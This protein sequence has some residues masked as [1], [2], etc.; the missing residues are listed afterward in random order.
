M[1]IINLLLLLIISNSLLAVEL[2]VNKDCHP[3]LTS[4]CPLYEAMP[5]EKK[6]TFIISFLILKNYYEHILNGLIIE[7]PDE[8]KIYKSDG[9]LSEIQNKYNLKFKVNLN[10]M[11][12]YP[13]NDLSPD[14]VS[15]LFIFN[16]QKLKTRFHSNKILD[17]KKKYF[18][19]RKYN[20]F[21]FSYEREYLQLSDWKSLFHPPLR[22]NV[23]SFKEKSFKVTPSLTFETELDK[24]TSSNLTFN[25][26][27]ELLINNVSY[28]RKIKLIKE[29]KEFVFL[30]VMS[31][32]PSGESKKILQALT[33]KAKEGVKVYVV[34]ERFWN[35]LLF[36]KSLKIL[37]EAGVKIGLSKDLIK[38]GEEQA[39]FH[40]KYLVVDGDQSI[41]GGQNLVDR[42]HLST[43]YNHYNKDIDLYSKGPLAS[44]MSL[45]FLKLWR[46]FSDEVIE[47]SIFDKILN[48]VKIYK[49]KNVIGTKN[50]LENKQQKGICRFLSQGPHS[51][52][53]MLSKV[54]YKIFNN[55]NKNII[56]TSQHISYKNSNKD[57]NSNLHHLLFDKSRDGV[58]IDLISNGIDGGVLKQNTSSKS[59]L[60][61]K[62][63]EKLNKTTGYLNTAFRRKKLKMISE[64]E[65]Y[66]V[67][68]HFQY[69]HS[70]VAL[71]DNSI[72]VISSFNFENYSAEHSYETAV[73]CHDEDIAKSLHLDLYVDRVNS[74]PI[75]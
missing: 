18:D 58:M 74:T 16:L 70:K 43:G 75:R 24:L 39:L 59:G 21:K 57:W 62:V 45:D 40:S 35:K 47:K 68:Q 42:S 73:I 25:N 52:K 38:L 41:S 37:K 72:S 56:Y 60:N 51:D 32:D 12:I 17:F 28:H 69:I 6:D 66:E 63:I 3:E 10:D 26:E 48:K 29:A 33:K 65:N 5:N 13:L 30:A 50:L 22:K 4:S 19:S 14:T 2:I 64:H 67:W 20:S 36:R 8:I 71:I 61:K 9:S 11:I 44:Q 1:K 34:L 55:A 49:D 54:F 7:N 23:I 53:Y 27:L 46:R 31:L 15:N